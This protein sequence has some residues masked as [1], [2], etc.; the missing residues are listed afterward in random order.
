MQKPVNIL[1]CTNAL[2][3][4]HAAV[5]LAS[6]LDNNRQLFFD[7]VV[8]HRPTEELDE[9]KV[10]HSLRQFENHS[11]RF[12]AF[13]IPPDLVLPLNP[14][15]HYTIDVYMRLWIARF[16]PADVSRVLYL[17]ADIVVVGSIE[18]LWCVD[19]A[20]ALLGSVDI[21]GSDRGVTRLGMAAEDGYFNSGVMV[22]DLKQWRDSG[23]K[24]TVLDYIRAYPERVLY[25]QDALN[26]CFH[27]RRKRLDYKW[28]VI[29]PFYRLP[30]PLPLARTE[31]ERVRREAVIIHFNGAS[32][33]WSYFCDH[34]RKADY[35]KYLSMTEWSDVVPADR[36]PVNMMRKAVGTILPAPCK[37]TAKLALAGLMAILS[38]AGPP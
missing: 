36:T 4:Q 24:K 26:A 23:A 29:W 3:L 32:K 7:I 5:G 10:H 38:L 16:F 34:P 19:L 30:S 15:A 17:D 12:Q 28:N 33:P 13:E 14:K 35:E 18:P 2:F 21:P 11:L 25:E 22:I 31:L 20:G 1:V 6:L 9:A 37:R 8:V 27:G